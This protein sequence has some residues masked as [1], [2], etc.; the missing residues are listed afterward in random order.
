MVPRY[1]TNMIPWVKALQDAGAVVSMDVLVAGKTE[2]YALLKPMLWQQG[3]LSRGLNA[4]K[5]HK[6]VNKPYDFPKLWPYWRHL[7]ALKPDIIVVRD[8]SRYFSLLVMLFSLFLP[9]KLVL[10]NQAPLHR[11]VSFVRKVFVYLINS[12]F[13]SSWMTPVLGNSKL[14]QEVLPCHFFVPF[15]AP[16]VGYHRQYKPG[17]LKILG[18]GKFERRKEQLTLLKALVKLNDIIPQWQLTW[19]GELSSQ[20]HQLWLEE[21]MRYVG[22]Q[23][24]FEKVKFI[25][26]QPPARMASYYGDADLFILPSRHEPASISVIEAM[27]HGL[28]VISSH[29][30]GTACYITEGL[31]GAIF[32]AG[33]TDNLAAAIHNIWLKLNN[34]SKQ[35]LAEIDKTNRNVISNEAFLSQL[36]KAVQ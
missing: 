18:I 17:S 26:N 25:T 8:P 5:R 22:E 21:I 2:D 36:S 1:H 30:N 14:V 24:L 33:N 16:M 29:E 12:L 15:V 34:N 4:L 3:N 13:K 27:A 23:R 11:K 32:E 9:G 6:G 35:F 19:V 7:K 28:P 10:Y 20:Q 31:N